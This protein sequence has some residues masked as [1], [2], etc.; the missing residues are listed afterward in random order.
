MSERDKEL[1]RLK[2]EGCRVSELANKF[3]I[4]SARVHQIYNLY[5]ARKQKA[6]TDPPF[7]KLL[8]SRMS[9][10]MDNYFKDESIYTDPARIM[11]F[12]LRDY[13]RVQNVGKYALKSLVDGMLALGYVKAG[14]KWLEW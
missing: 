7:K 11:S 1:C 5:L 4:S 6:E 2:E 14:D 3:G 9:N 12:T 13:R 8:T 10:A